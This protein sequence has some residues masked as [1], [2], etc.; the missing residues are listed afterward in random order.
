MPLFSYVP[1]RVED[2]ILPDERTRIDT[3]LLFFKRLGVGTVTSRDQ[4][5]GL[6]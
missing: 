3:I 2:L 4:V 6:Q 1:V 5:S